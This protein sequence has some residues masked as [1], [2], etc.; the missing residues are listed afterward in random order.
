MRTFEYTV[1]D[2]LGL[3]ARPAGRLVKCAKDFLSQI[4]VS[5]N[6]KSGD[7]KRL[8]GLMKIAIKRGERILFEIDGDDE[9]AA[10]RKLQEFCKDNL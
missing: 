7:A 6:G 8:I 1:R 5:C 10:E 9:E 2:E 4:N 3:H